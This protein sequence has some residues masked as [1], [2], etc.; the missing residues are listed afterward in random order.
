MNYMR[1]VPLEA[2]EVWSRN[3]TSSALHGLC[4]TFMYH[5]RTVHDSYYATL[6]RSASR[7]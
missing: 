2:H 6:H 4:Q 1:S 7:R 5:A 3:K